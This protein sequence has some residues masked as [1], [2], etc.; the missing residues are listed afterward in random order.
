VVLLLIFGT[1]PAVL[2]PLMIAIVSIMTTYAA[3]WG[4][5]YVTDV[6]VIVQ[7]LIGLVG[8]GIGIDYSLLII[9]R[10]R[11][12]LGLGK[13]PHEAL[14]DTMCHAGHS[15]IVSGS[16]VAIGLVSM[17]LLP[18]PFIRAIGLGGLLIPVMSVFVTI[19]LLPAVLS[20]LGTR[21]NRLR[22][23]V[24]W[25]FA[26]LDDH[27]GGKFWPA[28]A[29]FVVRRPWPVFLVGAV[30]VAV[31][32]APAFDI[33]PANS[34][35]KNEPASGAAQAGRVQLDRAGFPQGVFSPI[36]IVL[37]RGATAADQTT[38]AKAMAEVPG[39]VGTSVPDGWSSKGVRLVEVLQKDDPASSATTHTIDRL[40]SRLA[41]LEP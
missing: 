41:Q 30:L 5:T 8:L 16:T 23:P 13:E 6:S 34:Q 37:D 39:V 19:T 10:Y 31:I 40:K 17:I 24:L 28:W 29:G 20:L 27:S 38:V 12:E 14:V 26:N 32:V 18:L 2:M 1:L 7:F 15:V 25:R 4:L 3:V 35:V 36:N 11:E 9:F 22:I 21:I 33:N